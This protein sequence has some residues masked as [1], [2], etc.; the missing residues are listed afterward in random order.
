MKIVTSSVL[1][2]DQAKALAIYTDVLRFARRPMC[3]P[4][5]IVG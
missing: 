5:S 3:P 1:V 2:D 4:A